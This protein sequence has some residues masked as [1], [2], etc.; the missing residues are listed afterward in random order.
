MKRQKSH[1]MLELC[2]AAVTGIVIAV[3]VWLYLKLANAGIS[4]IWEIIPS[5]MNIRYYTLIMCLAG[6]LIVGIFHR[7]YGP[8]PESMADAVRRV[9]DTGYYPFKNLHITTIA[10]FLSLFFGGSVGPESG[11][12]CLL[13][14]LCFWAIA[15]FRLARNT[16]Q[17]CF[18]ENP[19]LSGGYVLRQ[20][21]KCM[22]YSADRI[23]SD[24]AEPEWK[25]SEQIT[26]GVTTGV[27]ALIIYLLL[28]RLFGSAFTIPHLDSGEIY[29][30]D[31]FSV[32]LLAAAGIGAGYL[33]LIFRKAASLFFGRLRTRRLDILN[34]VLGG[35]ILGLIGTALPMTMFSGG[36]DM[37][38]IQY[39]YYQYTPWLLILIGTVKLF[40]TNVCI[41]SGWRGGHF[42]PVIFSGLSIGY[43][44]STLLGTSQILSVVVVTAALLGTILQQPIGAL[45]L[46][47]I[48][49][50]IEE[51]G[52]MTLICFAAGC[53]PVPPPL[54]MNPDS[55]GFICGLV[56]RKD[57]K[58]LEMHE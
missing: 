23:E 37:Q 53:I 45:A 11:L 8:Y 22:R 35:L 39:E 9:R 32:L 25:R 4:L 41:E 31:R 42:F 15:Q 46:M 14:G 2:F 44:L 47:V 5:H 54:R 3:L 40:L 55:K 26:T 29:M 30:R 10:A 49:F 20:M 6:G 52:W 38:L 7:A 56:H 12:V 21:F 34:A 13:L 16:L 27:I 58:K 48:F 17:T 50:P 28:N 43:G 19:G 18:A 51:I 24:P 1:R 36:S 57:R 33:Y